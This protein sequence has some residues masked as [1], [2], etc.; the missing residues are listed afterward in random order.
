MDSLER[1]RW[2]G[3]RIS[4]LGK[5]IRRCKGRGKGLLSPSCLSWL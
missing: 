3:V 2:K 4:F 5:W 1:A